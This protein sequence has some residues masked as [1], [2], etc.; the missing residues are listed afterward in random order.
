MTVA[1]T[2]C[3]HIKATS[4]AKTPEELAALMHF[5]NLQPLFHDD[6]M[7]KGSR[8]SP[9]D[10]EFWAANIFHKPDFL[11][12]FMPIG[13]S[14]LA[15]QEASALPSIDPVPARVH[16]PE[17]QPEPGQLDWEQMYREYR[18]DPT[19]TQDSQEDSD[20]MDLDGID[21]DALEAAASASPPAYKPKREWARRW[22][23]DCAVGTYP[24]NDI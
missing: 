6:N 10:D 7:H 8:W 1:N 16:V 14:L 22:L 24:A 13:T 18:Y 15:H 19:H 21:L 4:L 5:T 3:D 9:P 17:T 20:D 23:A 11:A 12:L 2:D